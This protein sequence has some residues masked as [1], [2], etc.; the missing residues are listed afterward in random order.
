MKDSLN[1]G[2]LTSDGVDTSLPINIIGK[3]DLHELIFGNRDWAINLVD[4]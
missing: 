1:V 4:I 3:P 2:S